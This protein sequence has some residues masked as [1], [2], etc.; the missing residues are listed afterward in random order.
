GWRLPTLNELYRPFRAG[1][2][3]TAA[4]AALDPE[5]LTGA[6][7]GM[8]WRPMPSLTLRATGYWNR[9]RGAIANVTLA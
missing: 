9:L 6:E 3:A 7:I 1:A 5:R 4:N 2:D 8:D